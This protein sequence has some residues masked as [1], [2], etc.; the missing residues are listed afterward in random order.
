MS[1]NNEQ[2]FNQLYTESYPLLKRYVFHKADQSEAEDILQETYYQAYR[3]VNILKEHPNPT[4]WLMLTCKN[5]LKKHIAKNKKELDKTYIGATED[6]INNMPAVDDYDWVYMEELKKI[7]SDDT[8]Y[9]LVKKYVEGY[10]VEEL[11]KQLN[12]TDG[13]CK[14]RLKRAKKE[15]RKKIKILIL[16]LLFSV[17]KDYI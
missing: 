10:S 5:I 6:L 15:A 7:L 1:R 9:L 2:Y 13:A 14:M 3:N 11:A 4:G 8:Y 16:A 17:F 12:I